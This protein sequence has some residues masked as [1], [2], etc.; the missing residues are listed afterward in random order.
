MNEIIIVRQSDYE[1]CEIPP[2][3]EGRKV[4][5]CSG[6]PFPIVDDPFYDLKHPQI[7]NLIIAS[8]SVQD[9][10]ESAQDFQIMND[11]KQKTYGPKKK[12]KGKIK[13]GNVS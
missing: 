3:M 10:Q 6:E 9:F 13:N 2:E 12:R 11:P 1:Y 4:I 5:I 8:P 7:N